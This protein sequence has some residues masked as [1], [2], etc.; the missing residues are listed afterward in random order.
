MSLGKGVIGMRN[1]RWITRHALVSIWV[2][3]AFLLL[4]RPEVMIIGRLGDVA[5]YPATGLALALMVAVSPRYALLFSLGDAL[6]GILF[7]KQPIV[8]FGG[9]LGA[10]AFGSSYAFAAYLLRG[11]FQI[12]VSL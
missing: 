3:V 4:N 11:S 2:F 6:A 5:W 12:E 1:Q 10:I 8:S 9:T 7:Y